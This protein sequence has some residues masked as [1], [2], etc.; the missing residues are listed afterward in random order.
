MI[1]YFS[2]ARVSTRLFLGSSRTMTTIN[3]SGGTAQT[4]SLYEEMDPMLNGEED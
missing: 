3:I 2:A 4:L 1:Q